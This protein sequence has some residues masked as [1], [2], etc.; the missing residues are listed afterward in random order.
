MIFK[1]TIVKIFFI[2]TILLLITNI[3]VDYF[4]KGEKNKPEVISELT[5]HQ[6][7]SVFIDVL[8][9]YG[10]EARWI[11]TKSVKIPEEDSIKKQF[12][13]KLPADLPIPLIIRDVNKI[14]ETD[15]T[16]F[17]SEE[18]KIFGVTEI[19]IYTNEILKLQA[20]LIPDKT[21]IRERNNLI[22]I[23][24]D[25]M[26]L[27]QS[28]FNGFLS[29]PYKIAMAVIPSENSSIQVDTLAKYSKESVVLINDENTANNF[30]L[31]KNDQ[32]ALL[33]NSIYNIITKLKVTGKIIID[34]NSRL[35]QSTIYNFVRD[36]FS[37]R[38]I[39]LVPLSSFI[40]LEANN[41][42]ELI[43]KF[44]FHCMDGSRGRN[45]IFYTSYEN[46][47]LIRDE[48]ELFKKKGH[49][50]LSYYS[51]KILTDF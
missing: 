41:E 20:T 26:Y 44:K 37:K 35:Y 10:I 3:A 30:K 31:D 17:V 5:T 45:K 22:F 19:R 24:N 38:K 9:Q 7:D 51:D 11:S 15:I 32:K 34:E 43:S 40:F 48:L 46:F 23:I 29:L 6:I 39:S 8:D 4:S 36:E 28:D 50:V 1:K 47:L 21:T 2:L 27:S 25:A 13:V 16:G 18:K 49:K 14:I 12:I 33:L 42:N